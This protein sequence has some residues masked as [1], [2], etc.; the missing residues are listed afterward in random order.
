[1][2][3]Q[4]HLHIIS[5]PLLTWGNSL[6]LK[7]YPLLSCLTMDLHSMVRSLGN[8]P[9]TLTLYTPHHHPISINLM[10]S[11]RPWWRKSRMLTRK[12][13]DPPMLRLEHYFSYITHPS[14]QTSHPQQRLYMVILLKEQSFQ[15][16]QKVSIYVR[17]K[18]NS[19]NFKK[20]RRKTLTK[21]TEPNIYVFSK[22]RNKSSSFPTNKAQAPLSG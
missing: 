5:R 17:F 1:M 19:S 16:H 13:M 10:D 15:D 21:P 11:L 9:M 2:C 22:S 8:L 14:W 6:Q 3:F 4:W 20:N 12:Q 18:R 7:A